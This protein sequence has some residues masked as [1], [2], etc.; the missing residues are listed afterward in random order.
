[1]AAS[2]T[3][4]NELLVDVNATLQEF[5]TTY[6]AR[7]AGEYDPDTLEKGD[8][9]PRQIIGLV[10]DQQLVS[11]LTASRSESNSFA[12]GKKTLLLTADAKP[13]AGEEILVDG[14]WFPLAKLRPIKPADIILLYMLDIRR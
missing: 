11:A 12:L 3:F 14:Q 13:V 8:G 2:D 6:T 10:A 5:G 9:A 1:M 4:Y 7:K